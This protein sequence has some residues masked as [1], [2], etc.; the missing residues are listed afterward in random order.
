MLHY[1]VQGLLHTF[2]F[3]V[4][5]AYLLRDGLESICECSI[6]SG[7]HRPLCRLEPRGTFAR[8]PTSLVQDYTSIS[9]VM[10]RHSD[11]HSLCMVYIF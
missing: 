11:Y 6:S 5:L 2:Y 7:D 3:P 4:M 1:Q 10:G 9:P 8:R